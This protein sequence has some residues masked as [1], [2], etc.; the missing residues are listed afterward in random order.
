[1]Q[2][3]DRD[4]DVRGPVPCGGAHASTTP[5]MTLVSFS[6][7][8][9]RIERHRTSLHMDAVAMAHTLS[10]LHVNLFLIGPWRSEQVAY[11]SV[12]GAREMLG[13]PFLSAH[14]EWASS[15]GQ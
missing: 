5:H 14:V 7:T 8:L 9:L 2:T 12:E 15:T 6:L 1:M 3:E 10:L 4:A 11:A 13:R